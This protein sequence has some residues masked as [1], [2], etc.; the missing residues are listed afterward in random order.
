MSGASWIEIG[1]VAD[2][3]IRG[4]RRVSLHGHPVAIFR[5][6]EDEIYALIDRCPHRGGPLSE[7]IVS[8][9]SVTCP[10]HNWVIDL[11]T[12]CAHAPDEGSSKTVA[13]KLEGKRI[14]LKLSEERASL[15]K[16][17]A[18]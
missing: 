2:I 14:F 12:G 15:D 16:E 5:T 4:S 13:V 10:L 11:R 8:G 17:A 3:P 9:H 6:G 18:A 1:Q 7:G